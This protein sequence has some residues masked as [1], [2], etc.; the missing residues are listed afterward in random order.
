M[1]VTTLS[2]IVATRNGGQDK[3]TFVANHRHFAC[4]FDEL[5]TSEGFN[6]DRTTVGQRWI[7]FHARIMRRNR[8]IRR[9][10]G[11]L[12]KPFI[13]WRHSRSTL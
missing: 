10:D 6:Q 9:D 12:G 7:Y 1:S 2:I 5:E 13:L 8:A 11:G 3:Q 4:L